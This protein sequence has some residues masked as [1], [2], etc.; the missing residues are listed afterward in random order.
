MTGDRK[1]CIIA[2]MLINVTKV[3]STAQYSE[4]LKLAE[5]VNAAD[6][7]Y[8]ELELVD[9]LQFQGVIENAA[10]FLE[11]HGQAIAK[12]QQTCS[13]CLANFEQEFIVEIAEAFTNKQEALSPDDAYEVAF[14]SGDEIDIAPALLR[15]LLLELPMRPLCRPDCQ[16]LCPNCGADLNQQPCSCKHEDIDIRLSKLQALFKT[17]NNDKE[18]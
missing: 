6:Y 12:L 13:R 3:K 7:G 5:P 1:Y 9:N 14:F 10:P 16:G 17:M 18:V 15:S 2:A 8:P 11:L 4:R